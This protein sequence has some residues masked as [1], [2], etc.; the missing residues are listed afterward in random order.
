MNVVLE[1]GRDGDGL[2]TLTRAVAFA[3][4]LR[5]MGFRVTVNGSLNIDARWQQ[6][7][8]IPADPTVGDPTPAPVPKTR[9]AASA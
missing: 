9:K 2:D 6:I 8:R 7:N 3:K 1:F 5:A 4:E